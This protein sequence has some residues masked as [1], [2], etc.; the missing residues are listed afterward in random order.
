ME[1]YNKLTNKEKLELVER[2]EKVCTIVL[3]VLLLSGVL[4]YMLM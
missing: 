2:D 4:G 3:I 1:H